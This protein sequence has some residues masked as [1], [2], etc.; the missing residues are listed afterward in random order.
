MATASRAHNEHNDCTVKALTAATGLSYDECHHALAKQGRKPRKGCHFHTVGKRAAADLGFLMETMDWRD[1]SAKTMISAERD[2]R[3]AKGRYVLQVRAH[4]A[5][6]VDGK[7]IDWSQGRRHRI[8]AVYSFTPI[9]KPEPTKLPKGSEKWQSF[10]KYTKQDNL[11][12][13]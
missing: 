12:L 2:R 10:R 4:V 6:L 13:F 11:E 7:V 9:A 1:Y 8:K 3:L 5:A